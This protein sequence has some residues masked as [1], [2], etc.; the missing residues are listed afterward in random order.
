MEVAARVSAGGQFSNNPARSGA[1]IAREFTH[2]LE[3]AVTIR[4]RVQTQLCACLGR[5]V[6]GISCEVERGVVR[7]WGQSPTYYQKQLAQ[8]AV[9]RVDGV[10]QVVNEIVVVADQA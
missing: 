1:T 6:D 4:K 2:Q 8:E 3:P 10:R 7:L 5:A 9:R